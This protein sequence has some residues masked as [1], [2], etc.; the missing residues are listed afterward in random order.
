MQEI[1]RTKKPMCGCVTQVLMRESQ[2]VGGYLVLRTT[3]SGNHLVMVPRAVFVKWAWHLRSHSEQLDDAP[4][5]MKDAKRIIAWLRC[6]MVM[7]NCFVRVDGKGKNQ[8]TYFDCSAVDLMEG[9][10]DAT[11]S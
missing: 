8:R 7:F 1:A 4:Y 2:T 6:R 10:Y 11:V 5:T 9:E 3:A